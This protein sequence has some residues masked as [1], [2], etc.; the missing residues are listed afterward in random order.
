VRRKAQDGRVTKRSLLTAVP[1]L[2]G[3][4]SG[5]AASPVITAVAPAAAPGKS[6]EIALFGENLAGAVALWTSFPAEAAVVSATNDGRA[7]FRLTVPPRTPPGVGAVRVATTNGVSSL[8]L[9]VIDELPGV[10]ESGTNNSPARA[11]WLRPPVAVDG[12]GEELS[13]DYFKVAARQGQALA[14][15]VV[16]NRLGSRLDP[17]VRWLDA[18]G[19]EV[20]HGDD[21]PGVAPDCRFTFKPP[22]TGEYTLELRD[23]NYGGGAQFRYRLRLGG[24]PLPR[25]APADDPKPAPGDG[26]KPVPRVV[27][28]EPND[29]PARANKL[30]L[31][32]I[33]QGQFARAGD[34]DFFEFEARQD[35]RLVF[36]GRTRSLG[37]PCDLF[38]QLQKADGTKLADGRVAGADEG[39]L[40]NRFQ[41]AGAYRL[42]VEELTRRGGPDLDYRLHI[43]PFQRG[44]ALEIE[45]DK[46]EAGADGKFE[47][48]VTATRTEYDGPITLALVGLGD[49]VTL[50]NNV[51]AEKK[52]ETQ[53]KAKLS[54]RFAPDRITHF[55]VVGQARIGGSEFTVT[56][57]TLPALRKLWPTLRHPPAEL[58]GLIALGSKGGTK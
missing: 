34:R 20:A 43:A 49:G 1:A 9:L 5:L 18:H 26:S 3:A 35:E 53:L 39:S 54:A 11:Q 48:K 41:E 25:R 4:M 40:T 17:V 57:A 21:E 2:C 50:E 23:V 44:F 58:D 52:T 33:V 10:A 15:E 36:L 42:V 14:L 24:A 47:L 51:I 7:T 12:A 27:E 37:S 31:P 16:A 55:Q 28:R 32:A 29:T 22:A 6:S 38:F 13:L 46:V 45:T 30:A 8:Q 19:R 56:A